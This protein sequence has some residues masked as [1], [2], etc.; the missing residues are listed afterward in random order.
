[1]NRLVFVH[2]PPF[3]SQPLLIDPL[4]VAF[5]EVH[6][7][8]VDQSESSIIVFDHVVMYLFLL[9]IVLIAWGV[10][11]ATAAAS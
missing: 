8:E 9:M 6:R 11:V 4:C 7:L 3:V 1:M 2:S 10:V 5:I